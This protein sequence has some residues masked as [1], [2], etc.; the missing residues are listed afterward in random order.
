MLFSPL[1]VPDRLSEAVDETAWIQAMLDAEG[2]LARAEA[3]VGVI[4]AKAA[5]E[6]ARRC[7]AEHFDA[8]TIAV[9]AR[10]TGNPAEPLVRALRRL[11]PEQSARY[12]HYGATSQDIVDTASMLV[13]KRSLAH[14]ELDLGRLAAALAELADEHRETL[15]VGRT[16]LQQALPITFGLKAAGWLAGVSR[17]HTGL[18]RLHG[19][20]LTAGLGGA[21]GTLAALG[22]AGIAVLGEF[23]RLLGLA[24]PDLPWHTER[25]RVAEIGAALGRTA[26]ALDKIA[27]D[28]TLL[29][30]TEVGEVVERSSGRRGASSTM[31]QKRNPVCSVMVRACARQAQANAELLM[32]TMAQEHER[33]TGAWQAEWPA[34]SA[35]LAYTGGAA[36]WLGEVI[37]GLEVDQARMRAHLDDSRGLLMAE[38]VA[39]LLSEHIGRDEAHDVIRAASGLV[40]AGKSGFRAVLLA[41]DQIRRHLSAEEI[42]EAM[43]PATYLGAA[44]S[45]IDRA[46]A[47]YRY[48]DD[49]PEEG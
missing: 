16:L 48:S 46:L 37:A 2:A 14:I 44:P 42:D 11:V 28:I 8:V 3:Q 36:A 20:C 31:P 19:D 41:D 17:A 32:R 47:R 38:R 25:S 22:N 24:E 12:V 21:A 26:G 35:A 49:S 1:F 40:S 5:E 23:A 30:Q 43:D 45:F 4:P 39:F 27:L 6:I 18:R 33:A 9:E 7:V 29:A 34:L 13:T 10:S 15:M